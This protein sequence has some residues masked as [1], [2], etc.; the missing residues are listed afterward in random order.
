MVF[1]ENLEYLREKENLSQEERA[2]YDRHMNR[3]SL[4]YTTAILM[5]ITPGIWLTFVEVLLRGI[6]HKDILAVGMYIIIG[7]AVLLLNVTEI[8][9]ERFKKRYYLI[10]DFYSRHERSA[11][12]RKCVAALCGGFFLI[13][14]AV[15]MIIIYEQIAGSVLMENLCVGV[16]TMCLAIAGA[17]FIYFSMLD[18]KYDARKYNKEMRKGAIL[19]SRIS[20]IIMLLAVGYFFV[21]GSAYGWFHTAWEVYPAIISTLGV[22]VG[23]ICSN[24]LQR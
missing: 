20:G 22:K 21:M 6:V 9:H 16:F 10:R 12:N 11:F 17:L 19:I 3:R 4:I 1:K 18:E 24:I 23:V 8:N 5:I 2:L 15:S 13:I 14:L 7:I